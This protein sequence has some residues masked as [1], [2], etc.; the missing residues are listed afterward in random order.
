V[1][2]APTPRQ[3]DLSSRVRAVVTSH[4]D[5]GRWEEQVAHDPGYDRE[6]WAGLLAAGVATAG[7]AESAGGS[8]GGPTDQATVV[9]ELGRG[10]VPTPILDGVV[11]CGLVLAAAGSQPGRLAE[12]LAGRRRFAPVLE[13]RGLLAGSA[14]PS[15]R[16][17]RSAGGWTLEGTGRFVPHAAGAQELVVEA[18]TDERGADGG[19]ALF[20]VD[21]GADGLALEP[22]PTLDGSRRAHVTLAHVAVGADRV[23]AGPSST[24]DWLPGVREVVGL[25]AAAEMVGAAS[26]A[27][28][29]AASRA[30]VRVQFGS[31]IGSFEAVQHRLSDAFIDVRTARDAVYHALSAIER[32]EGSPALSSAAMAH[33]SEACRRVTA[34]AHQI[35]GGEGIL[36]DQPV[37]RWHRRVAGLVPS[38]GPAAGHRATVAA[39]LFDR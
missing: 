25:M 21:A 29:H 35:C 33:C 31:A 22:V 27:L 23:V 20:V 6:L 1:D 34:A 8:G 4:G 30:T 19:V 10:P 7:F 16:A 12:L 32:G 24:V 36:A 11:A 2:L 28:D 9:E 37:H 13:E 18:W 38:V 17:A 14:E 5:G 3:L 39:A 26:A 15:V